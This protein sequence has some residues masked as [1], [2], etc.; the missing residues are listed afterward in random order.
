M[1]VRYVKYYLLITVVFS[2]VD[3]AFYP[4]WD[5]KMSTKGWRRGVV[6]TALDV[7][8]KLLYVEPG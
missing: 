5:G 4:P 7:S 8:T 1:H 2:Q 6:E 3:S